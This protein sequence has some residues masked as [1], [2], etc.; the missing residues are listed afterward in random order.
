MFD[1]EGFEIDV[2]VEFV[3]WMN[4][5]GV[6]FKIGL[7][8]LF[9]WVGLMLFE[10]VWNDVDFDGIIFKSEFECIGYFGSELVEV[11]LIRVFFEL[12]IE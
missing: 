10:I 4:E 11:F 5:E 3:N 6:C 2:F 7:I 1:D 9:V 12:Y 8:G